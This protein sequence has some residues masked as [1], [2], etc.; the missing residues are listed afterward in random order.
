MDINNFI[1]DRRR[2]KKRIRC[3]MIDYTIITIKGRILV[4]V[5]LYMNLIQIS[6][7]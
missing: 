4:M 1:A 6:I 3:I 2:E 5:I 7:Y